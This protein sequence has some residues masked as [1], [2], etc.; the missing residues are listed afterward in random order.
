[1]K[2]LIAAATCAAL[3]VVPAAAI[4]KPRAKV[5]RG[6]FQ[7]VGSD[8]AYT[9]GKFGKAQLVDGKRNDKLSVHVRHLGGK[10]RYVF[11]LQQAETACDEGA[12][13]GTDVAGWKYRRGGVLRTSR[14]GNANSWARSHTF[15]ADR[16]T[17]YF[18]GVYT[19]TPTGDPGEMVL[20]AKLSTKSHKRGG[21]KPDKHR[22]KP[23]K[24]SKKP[25]KGGHKPEHPG[26]RGDA[27][28]KSGDTPGK[29]GDTPGKRGDT[30]GKSGDTPGGQGGGKHPMRVSAKVS[31][32]ILH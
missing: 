4:A 24:G 12:P 13:G 31:R 15:T 1:M 28:G 20:C 29:S 17:E 23:E 2:K 27:P 5:Y 30:P 10:T 11:R 32:K 9:N 25:G 16:D 18:V 22:G 14:K 21:K 6:T 8:G 3:A 19:A 26:K 7:A